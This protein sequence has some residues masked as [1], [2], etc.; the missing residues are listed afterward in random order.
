VPAS[1]TR[2]GLGRRPACDST[3]HDQLRVG[4]VGDQQAVEPEFACPAQPANGGTGIGLSL[5]H[6]VVGR[7]ALKRLARTRPLRPIVCRSTIE[8]GRPLIDPHTHPC[9]PLLAHDLGRRLERPSAVLSLSMRSAPEH[10]DSRPG[11]GGEHRHV[12]DD[13]FEAACE[14]RR[15]RIASA[16]GG[17][18]PVMPAS[19]QMQHEAYECRPAEPGLVDVNRTIATI[20]RAP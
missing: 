18:V 2:R 16:A 13:R 3:Q 8:P 17:A 11:D 14:G 12:E 6:T 1:L 4:V 9:P 19:A 7:D 15:V 5:D 20:R 10:G